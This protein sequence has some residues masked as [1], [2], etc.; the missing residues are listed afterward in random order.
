MIEIIF[1]LSVIPNGPATDISIVK[2]TI[3]NTEVYDALWVLLK[4]LVDENVI[5]NYT[6]SIIENNQFIQ[7][8]Y[9]TTPENAQLF[10][11]EYVDPVA[12]WQ[13]HG[14]DFKMSLAEIDPATIDHTATI[15]I[16]DDN[17]VLYGLE[18]N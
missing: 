9:A 6:T 1:T 4:P 7:S 2:E 5:L 18:P 12:W 15:P 16:F 17:N 14:I 10:L 11:N 8:H 13:P 3:R